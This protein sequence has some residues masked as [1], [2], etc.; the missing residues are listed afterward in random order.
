MQQVRYQIV[1]KSIP[2]RRRL[3]KSLS[4]DK[5]VENQIE[6]P[7]FNIISP[8]ESSVADSSFANYPVGKPLEVR[9]CNSDV[10]TGILPV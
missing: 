3:S 7:T 5:D 9:V 8:S 2:A 6:R 10:L 4:P 1:N